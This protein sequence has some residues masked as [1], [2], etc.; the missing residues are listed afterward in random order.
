MSEVGNGPASM[1]TFVS[2]L[3]K[4]EIFLYGSTQDNNVKAQLSLF[5]NYSEQIVVVDCR[6]NASK[7]EG[8]FVF[9]TWNINGVIVHGSLS[10]NVLSKFSGC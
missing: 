7:C 3:N 6:A 5:G 4:K 10:L 9:P 8:I 2:C 1:D